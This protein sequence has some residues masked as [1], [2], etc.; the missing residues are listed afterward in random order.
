MGLIGL[1]AVCAVLLKRT[2]PFEI[3][4]LLSPSNPVRI[5][6]EKD[7]K[8]FD[9]EASAWVVV[10]KNTPFTSAEIQKLSQ[11]VSLAL[12]MNFAFDSVV[13]PH[14]AKYFEADAQSI[15][16]VPFIKDGE[17]TPRALEMLN[18]EMW[19]NNLVRE[20]HT[21]FLMSFKFVQ[22]LPRKEEQPAVAR[23]EK[24]LK[25]VEGDNPGVRTGILGAKIAS[26]SFLKEMVFQQ[27]VITPL[28]LLAIGLFLFF[29]YRSGQILL[30]NF[31]VMFVVYAAT[32]CLIMLVEGG[33][34]PYS[35]FALMFA[36]IVSTADL[37]HFF[38]RF[39]QLEGSVEYRL[40]ETV[41]IAKVPCLLASLTT[42]AGFIALIVNQNLP[43]RYFGIYCAFACM[44]EWCFI[45][46]VLPTTL[47]VFNFNPQVRRF[48]A[49]T[50]S[51]KIESFIGKNTKPIIAL[52]LLLIVIGAGTSFGLHVDDNFYTKFVNNHPL[53]RSIDLFS[54]GFDF[55]GS[56]DVVVQPKKIG[57]E[58]FNKE[59]FESMRNL[60]KD[61]A[62]NP[63]I[64]RITSVRQIDDELNRQ[65]AGALPPKEAAQKKEAILHMFNDYG[66]LRGGLNE[67]TGEMRTA[68]FLRSMSTDALDDVLQNVEI[69][70]GKYADHLSIR[71]SGFSVVRSYINGRVIQD[72]FESFFSS[73]ILIFLCYLYQYRSWKWAAYALIP[74]AIPLLAVSGTMS[75]FKVPIDTNLVI[76]ICVAFGIV[77]DNTVHL[78]YVIQQ[79]QRKGFSYDEALKRGLNLIGIAMFA[80][81]AI[82]LVCLPVFLLGDLKLFGHV[83]I[84]LSIAFVAAF[85]AD[86]FTFP[87][88]Q[89]AWGWNFSP[90]THSTASLYWL[91]D[92]APT[93]SERDTPP[94]NP[95]QKRAPANSP[96]GPQT[97]L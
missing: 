33:L 40:K 94:V 45:F 1:C 52:S 46:Y 36:F 48:D 10:E 72:F 58:R 9:D 85:L 7:L 96:E 31:F 14:N 61:L 76:L 64:S 59:V 97:P 70:K 93:V 90:E 12:E 49:H 56:M 27:R 68:V 22:D 23:L 11:Q 47:R 71:A 26:A 83:A 3:Q 77:G 4:S 19:K 37:L 88:L 20:D 24:F 53:S 18:T 13:G 54:K 79:E 2:I 89:K 39:Q 21:A 87:A 60:E 51:M 25:Q 15:K 67:S 32:L 74:N 35:S 80:T 41:R 95:E 5:Q 62:A 30:W 57:D 28:L 55:V 92:P 91:E 50:W 43:I 34:G 66:V 16:L 8:S 75:L 44:F 17:W 69:L 6:Y 73:F 65:L 81:S 78:S 63:Q 86:L 29:C 42:A 84:F 82:F 38:S